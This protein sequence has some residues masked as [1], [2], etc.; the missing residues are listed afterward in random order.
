[1]DIDELIERRK[2]INSKKEKSKRQEKRVAKE[3]RGRVTVGSG[4]KPLDKGDVRNE[5]FLIECK[6]TDKA[7]ITLKKDYINK[8]KSEAGFK[9]P[10]LNIEIQDENWYVIRK[11]EFMLLQQ[12]LRGEIK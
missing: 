1:M 2:K 10:A 8:I 5:E 12:F 9:I 3:I 4:N 6:R 11:Q 7:Q